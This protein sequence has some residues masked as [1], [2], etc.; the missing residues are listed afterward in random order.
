M[1]TNINI[2][3]KDAA[4]TAFVWKLPTYIVMFSVIGF[5]FWLVPIMIKNGDRQKAKLEAYTKIK[6]ECMQYQLKTYGDYDSV[7]CGRIANAHVPYYR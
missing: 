7:Q 1:T 5:L 6:T 3:S 4:L 2:N